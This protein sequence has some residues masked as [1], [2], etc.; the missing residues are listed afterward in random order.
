M[1]VMTFHIKVVPR[2]KTI[3]S[4]IPESMIDEF[5]VQKYANKY[6]ELTFDGNLLSQ[7]EH[8]CLDELR[9]SENEFGNNQQTAAKHLRL[10]GMIQ[11]VTIRFSPI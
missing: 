3:E 1:N 4:Y 6:L 8:T 5:I 2:V 10:A 7:L 11:S 9:D